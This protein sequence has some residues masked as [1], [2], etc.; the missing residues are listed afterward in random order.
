MLCSCFEVTR[1]CRTQSP[2]SASDKVSLGAGQA[3]RRRGHAACN[4]RSHKGCIC[5]RLNVLCLLFILCHP[6]FQRHRTND[7]SCQS[8]TSE[9]LDDSNTSHGSPVVG[10]KGNKN[11]SPGDL[12]LGAQHFHSSGPTVG[13]VDLHTIKASID[14]VPG[15]HTE[16]LHHLCRDSRSQ[17][18]NLIVANTV[19]AK[20]RSILKRC[21]HKAKQSQ[22]YAWLDRARAQVAFQACEW[23]CRFFVAADIVCWPLISAAGGESGRQAASTFLRFKRWNDSGLQCVAPEIGRM[24]TC[25]HPV[26]DWLCPSANKLYLSL[27]VHLVGGSG[28]VNPRLQTSVLPLNASLGRGPHRPTNP[29]K[30]T[31][32]T[33]IELTALECVHEPGRGTDQI[34]EPGKAGLLEREHILCHNQ[35]TQ[36]RDTHAGTRA[37]PLL[38]PDHPNRDTHAENEGRPSRRATR[39]PTTERHSRCRCPPVS[40]RVGRG[41]PP[42]PWRRMPGKGRALRWPRAPLAEHRWAGTLFGGR[43]AEEHMQGHVSERVRGMAVTDM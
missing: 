38:Q 6:S 1:A 23:G 42:D 8:H 19:V 35:A 25:S 29:V 15:T 43:R 27:H 7:T 22:Q 20:P 33:T 14:C 21:L 31:T 30:H 24:L 13:A 2:P 34:S 12:H 16:G 40:S 4:N 10:W 39:P 36:N 5:L 3:V 26:P 17:L 41:S 37:N 11:P 9:C 28:R 32:N 18:L